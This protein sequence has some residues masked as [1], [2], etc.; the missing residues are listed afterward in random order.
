MTAVV[1]VPAC[2][3]AVRA[4]G[5]TVDKACKAARTVRSRGTL[6]TLLYER[7]VPVYRSGWPS[8]MLLWA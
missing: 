6:V 7:T 3:V 2:A 5:R 8:G 4:A 1:A